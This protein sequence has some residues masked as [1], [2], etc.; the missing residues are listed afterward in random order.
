M[1][2]EPHF[3]L[4]GDSRDIP[5]ITGMLTRLPVYA[6][7]QVYLEVAAGIQQRR[8]PAPDGMTVTWLCRDRVAA[9]GPIAP[10]GELAA[11][12]VSAWISEWMP[13]D[14]DT[15]PHP[16]VIWIGCSTSAPVTRL[17]RDLAERLGETHL[18]HPHHP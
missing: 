4:V 7:G 2:A 3:L 16:Y 14:H 6:T 10:R 18:H 12:A 8:L 9:A 5:A 11:R 1:N 17:Y 13:D 15:Q